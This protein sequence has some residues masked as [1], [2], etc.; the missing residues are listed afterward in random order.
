MFYK[1]IIIDL[2][3]SRLLETRTGVPKLRGRALVCLSAIDKQSVYW[4]SSWA[5]ILNVQDIIKEK[6]N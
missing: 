4:S 2:I 3:I 6:T 1:H 5:R